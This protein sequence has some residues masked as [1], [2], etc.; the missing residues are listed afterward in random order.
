MAGLSILTTKIRI[1]VAVAELIARAMPLPADETVVEIRAR[2][3]ARQ[4]RYEQSQK[5]P[6]HD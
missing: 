6:Y 3:W 1:P 2:M 5:V 4:M